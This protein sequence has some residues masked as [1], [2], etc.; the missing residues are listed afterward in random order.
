[1]V[2]DKFKN[3]SVSLLTALYCVAIVA[4]SNHVT[5][6]GSADQSS[7]FQEKTIAQFAHNQL[8]QTTQPE[9]V[10]GNPNNLPVPVFKNVFAG[11]RTSAIT[12]EKLFCS[13]LSRYISRSGKI[14]IQFTKPDIIF[15][16]H[17]FR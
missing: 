6:S 13:V 16:F 15:P 9:S 14:Q 5:Y 11:I 8:Y 2:R 4:A 12:V 10:T 3:L 1:M 7:E 17:Y